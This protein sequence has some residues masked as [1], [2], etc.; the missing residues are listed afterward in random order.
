MACNIN[1]DDV[2][3]EINRLKSLLK[4]AKK[5]ELKS[6][7]ILQSVKYAKYLKEEVAMS[8]K[9]TKLNYDEAEQIWNDLR[10]G[11]QFKKIMNET[12]T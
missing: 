10:K 4:E 11:T 1:M 2:N 6:E 8:K 3:G 12:T 9:Q 5:E 7:H